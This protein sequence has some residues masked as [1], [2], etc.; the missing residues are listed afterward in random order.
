M[1]RRSWPVLSRMRT[2]PN[3]WSTRDEMTTPICPTSSA[4]LVASCS[5]DDR[6]GPSRRA[7]IGDGDVTG[8]ERDAGTST[9]A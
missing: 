9:R 6:T 2:S 8:E 1:T 4:R 5:F 3:S 7:T